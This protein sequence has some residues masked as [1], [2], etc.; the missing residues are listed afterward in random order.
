[1]WLAD[2]LAAGDGLAGYAAK[3]L[4]FG[5]ALVARARWMGAFL[6]DPPRPGLAGEPLPVMLHTGA[7]LAEIPG[8]A[9]LLAG[10]S[11]AKGG[12]PGCH[13]L[14]PQRHGGRR[15]GGSSRLHPNKR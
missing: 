7:P 6:E 3:A 14:M 8:L 5:A 11:E 15:A 13:T 4:P 10:L 1:M 9:G 2:A 12:K